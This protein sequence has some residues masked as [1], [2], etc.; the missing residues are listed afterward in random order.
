[1]KRVAKEVFKGDRCSDFGGKMADND[2]C[3]SEVVSLKLMA[4]TD[5]EAVPKAY[6]QFV[7]FDEVLD[8]YYWPVGSK[9]YNEYRTED[10]VLETDFGQRLWVRTRIN[11]RLL[12]FP[13]YEVVN[14]TVPNPEDGTESQMY[15]V[16]L[17]QKVT[18]GLQSS[19]TSL[20]VPDY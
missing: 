11:Y 20:S 9:G 19:A 1:M 3:F 8:V 10:H 14:S 4:T 13:G 18:S 17:S 12:T 16:I 2:G 5:L 7:C 6:F 15:Q